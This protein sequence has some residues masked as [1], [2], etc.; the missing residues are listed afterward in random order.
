M[1]PLSVLKDPNAPAAALLLVVIQKYGMGCFDTIPQLLAEQ[2]QS[3]FDVKLPE[4]QLDKIQA[5]MVLVTTDWV[6]DQ[7]EAFSTCIHLFSGISDSF[8]DFSTPEP[9]YIAKALADIYDLK[10]EE[11]G[12]SDEVLGYCGFI[13]HEHGLCKAP[14]IMPDA[15]MPEANECDSD[16]KDEAL[17]EIYNERKQ[18]IIDYMKELEKDF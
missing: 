7:W 2:I 3:D 11:S 12:F 18:Y 4:L 17:T 14:S 10:G 9:E 8:E 16:E 1:L 6:E 5:A 15:I 13:F